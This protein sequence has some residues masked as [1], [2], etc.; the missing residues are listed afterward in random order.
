[1]P[2]HPAALPRAR[3][4]ALLLALAL[5]ATCAPALAR[6]GQSTAPAA[7][8]ED[9]WRQRAA[10]AAGA[11]G[12]PEA[13]LAVRELV[14]LARSAADPDEAFAA[15]EAL[16]ARP[17]AHPLVAAEIDAMLL[18]EDITRGRL[19]SATRR[20]ARLG[21]VRSF[22]IAPAA[23]D[24]PAWRRVETSRAGVLT[25][26]RLVN[27]AEKNAVRA[28]F[29]LRAERPAEIALRFG[30]DDQARATLDG[31]PLFA[32][33]GRHGLVFDQDAVF[34]RLQPGWHLAEFTVD[35][36]EDAWGLQVR[37][38]AP[39]G[40]PAPAALRAE[41][42]PDV[43]GA[44]REAAARKAGG[45]SALR[46]GATIVGALEAAL[47]PRD[48]LGKAR[49]A[50]ELGAR[51]LPDRQR[52]RA[53]SLAREAAEAA[54]A[55]PDA[56]WAL[57]QVEQEPPR[58]RA[59]LERLLAARPAHPAALRYLSTY[60]VTLGNDELARVH[61][62]RALAACG[63]RDPYLE[64][65]IASLRDLPGFGGGAI[66]ALQRIARE[67]PRQ[68]IVA[69]RLA[70]FERR[71]GLPLSA[72][73][74]YER[75]L[76][77]VPGDDEAR[78]E[79]VDLLLEAGDAAGALARVD[80]ALARDPQSAGWRARRVR[81][82]LG[83]KRADRALADARAGL[84]IAPG[85]PDL[86]NLE[87]EA[88]LATGDAT[89]AAAAWQRAG[90]SIDGG[91]ALAERIAALT[92]V[93]DTFGA[94][95]TVSLDKVA[96]LEA[97]VA[98]AGDPAV[99]A[100]SKVNGL[101]A[102]A[103]G[104]ASRFHQAIYRVRHPEQAAAA[105]SFSI[106]YSP[107]LQRATVL[108]ARLVRR[109]GTVIPA[110]RTDRPLLP[111]AELRMWYDTR[112]IGLSFPHFEEGDLVEL[113]YRVSDRGAVNQ[114]GSGYAGEIFFAGE[115]VPVLSSRL[116]LDAER[117]LP[118]RYAL[119]HLPGPEKV[120]TLEREG[121][122]VTVI[123]LPPLPAYADAA[124]AP[125]PSERVPLALVGS[126]PDWETLAGVYAR[127]IEQ[128]TALDQDLKDTVQRLT[129]KLRSREA[130]V[131]AIYDWV[132]ENTRY[133]AL[134][135]GINAIKPYPVS[136]VFHRRHGDC[137]DKAALM[138]AMLREAGVE[139]HVALV[140]S[141]DQGA[142]DTTVPTFAHFDHAIVYVPGEELWLDGT[143]VHHN[144]DELPAGDRGS[145][146]L[147]VDERRATGRLTQTPRP[148]PEQAE[149]TRRETIQLLDDGGARVE[150]EVEARGERAAEERT[151]FRRADRPSNVLA[152]RLRREYP[153]L[154]LDRARF[155]AVGLDDP[156]VRYSFTGLAARFAHREGNR[157]IAPLGL[158]V[159]ALPVEA[160]SPG[161]QT[162]VALPPPFRQR[163]ETVLPL[164][165]GA[166]LDELPRSG[167][168]DSPWGRVGVEA[169]GT[170]DGAKV[171]TEL[172]FRGGTV[173]LDRVGEF[174][175][176]VE[177]A[178][179][180]LQ[181]RWVLQLGGTAPR[182]AAGGDR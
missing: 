46:D 138:M 102:R 67:Y 101:R 37:V 68:P 29:F 170:H 56:L 21:F 63:R 125:P 10:D 177:Q 173:P 42:P 4:L 20:A 157:L 132:I 64:A 72:R 92:G 113:R 126:V 117:E 87:G 84:E 6:S 9:W 139:A 146:A 88:L 28:R 58:R 137:K 159:P 57:Y 60:Y 41:W 35:Q 105:R 164:P 174:A 147:I 54:G 5:L 106:T 89:G 2:R 107:G 118:L 75:Y 166:R 108:E 91:A 140:R 52:A 112:V 22:E 136:A 30:A 73:A 36:D 180:L 86:L 38:T 133:V 158:F 95:W 77:L 149:L 168:I 19:D 161:R 151:Y 85:R 18:A 3:A 182:A 179:Q 114:V 111:E 80:E 14:D 65:W 96:E 127:L 145:L 152:G 172:E 71:E 99:V 25:L 7:C 13:M 178:R 155:G 1:M 153:D 76:Q 141:R 104:L 134:E 48:A 119:V 121:R 131:R 39:D 55:V 93:D 49:L 115:N 78:G 15:A 11:I 167:S 130:I 165:T 44:A 70:A 47:R 74:A 181:Q 27:P 83:E 129:G 45:W 69:G 124:D 8:F 123:E 97:A 135:F 148:A 100:V 94:E 110:Q 176:F 156:V 16:R 50:L 116:V 32:P 144:L 128:Q 142:I 33:G 143:V 154:A 81:L 79:L 169:H 17:G 98:P 31:A 162:P 23:G 163:T 51:E 62:E 26:D 66:A 43:A 120:S 24:D 109:D 90:E 103:N 40:G 122:T 34:V 12:K 160:P 59:A 61:A 175:A 82:L 150:I 53:A 171:V